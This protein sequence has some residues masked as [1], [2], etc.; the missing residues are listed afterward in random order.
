MYY[1][2]LLP[3]AVIILHNM[4]VFAMVVKVL[5]R[6]HR[7]GVLQQQSKPC[8]IRNEIV[9]RDWLKSITTLGFYCSC[10]ETSVN[11]LC[12]TVC[13]E[14]YNARSVITMICVKIGW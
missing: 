1:A 9:L 8:E 12:L 11:I 5:N 2:W 14:S 6:P 13:V 3:M 4:V 10:D 7:P